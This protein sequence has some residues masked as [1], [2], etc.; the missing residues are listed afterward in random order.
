MAANHLTSHSK[1]AISTII[2]EGALVSLYLSYNDLGESGVYEISKSLQTNLSLK[3]LFLSGSSI[4]P[5]GALSIAVALCHNH[6]LE[7]LGINDNSI[8]DDGAIAIAECLKT[9]RTLKYLDVSNNNITEIGATELVEVLTCNPILETL[10]ID[11]ACIKILE[12]YNKQLVYNNTI[13]RHYHAKVNSYKFGKHEGA[14]LR[15]T[16]L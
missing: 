12:P 13:G 7:I 6:T 3:K 9:N 4:G 8:L 1:T 15:R 16:W 2:Q 5:G 10:N 14:S 11:K